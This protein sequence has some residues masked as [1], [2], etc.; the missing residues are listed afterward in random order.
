MAD[1]QTYV[2][3]FNCARTP[4]DVDYFA[5]H[6][7]TALTA[8]APPDLL[9][10][11]LQEIAPVGYSFLGGALLSPYLGRFADAVAL[12]AERRFA[13]NADA[14]YV[15]VLARNVGMTA[16]VL[17]GRH[18]LAHRVQW[19]QTAGV[20]VGVYG[21][22]GNKGAV[23]VRMGVHGVGGGE[24]GTLT[25]VAAH[26]APFEKECE[27]RNEDWRT[28]CENLVFEDVQ[29]ASSRAIAPR[30]GGGRESEPLLA[31]AKKDSHPEGTLFHPASHVFFAGDLNYRASDSS[32]SASDFDSWPQPADSVSDA[33]HFSHLLKHD[34]LT[35]ERKAGRTLHHLEESDID[36]PPT[37][38]YSTAAQK[39][40][41]HSD[42]VSA[43]TTLADGRTVETTE[44]RA[45]KEE[46]WLWAKHRVPS[47]CDRI[48]YLSTVAPQV[49][50]YVA[51]PVQ[52]TSDHRPVALSC[53][54]PLAAP[55][56]EIEVEGP[57]EI[58][59][60]WR[61]QRARA[62][63]CEILVGLV[64]YLGWTWEG[65]ALLAGTIVGVV[66]GYLVLSALV[67][68]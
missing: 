50:K 62:R 23:G 38:K 42:I 33:R 15:Q 22:V 26:L 16:I 45:P 36:F 3:T 20:G 48:L 28:I 37:Y 13:G 40:V 58:N 12:A 41:A 27:R 64:A 32:P 67:G 66:G 68:M 53:A 47:W 9:V 63:M 1:L 34:Q 54:V 29:G 21:D 60:R 6:V 7:F 43:Q 17:F 5:A 2:V 56:A 46:V 10:L 14:R 24:T 52:P 51:L 11:C 25:F 19:L 49:H 31:P 8:S 55:G 4:V 18:S 65:E 39:H 35:R 59:P 30:G 57:F 44:V 61:E